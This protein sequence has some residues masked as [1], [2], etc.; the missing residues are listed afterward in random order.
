MKL[1]SISAI[2]ISIGVS[3]IYSYLLNSQFHKISP[4]WW[5]SLILFT[6]LFAAITLISFI[7]TDVKTFTGILLATGAIKLLL[8]MVVIFIYSFT[9][10]GGFFAFFLHFIGHYVLFTVFEIRYLLQLIKTKQNEN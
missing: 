5:H 9:L 3:F 1:K 6:G 2:L 4:Q 7:K 10:K 8:A